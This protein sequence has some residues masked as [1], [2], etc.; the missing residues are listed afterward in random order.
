MQLE[1]VEQRVLSYL[2][3]V[4]NPLVRFDTL[5]KYVRDDERFAEIDEK[6]FLGF[7]DDHEL[8]RVIEPAAFSDGIGSALAEVGLLGERA[9]MI[10]TRAPSPKQVAE[11]MLDQ[12]RLLAEALSTALRETRESGDEL[13]ETRVRRA[14]ARIDSL[15]K[16]LLSDQS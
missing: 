7:I 4:R 9:V 5:I 3:Q 13:R 6:D 12:L 15:R 8:F 10:A 14:L 1:E 11:L 16:R 2:Q